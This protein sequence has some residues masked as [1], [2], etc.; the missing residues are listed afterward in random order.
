MHMLSEA[1]FKY[2]VILPRKKQKCA[3]HFVPLKFTTDEQEPHSSSDKLFLVFTL[4][5]CFSNLWGGWGGR[6]KS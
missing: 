4:V 3:V 6:I 1:I 5:L 2:D